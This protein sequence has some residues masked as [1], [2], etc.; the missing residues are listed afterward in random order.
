[1]SAT[2]EDR[3]A[4]VSD[5]KRGLIRD[6]ARS[7]F[8]RS[9]I[10]G[11]SMRAIAAEAGST[12]G[13]IYVHYATKEELYADLLG[14]SLEDLLQTLAA[15][16]MAASDGHG[17]RAVLRA[18][19]GFYRSR[20]QDFDLSFYLHGGA[21]R[22]VGL[23]RELNRRLNAR[24]RE[25]I[26]LVGDALVA[27]GRGEPGDRRHLGTAASASV[28]GIVLMLRTGRLRVLDEDADA[29]LDAVAP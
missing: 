18:L 3:R 25:V 27:D 24:M 19:L 9:G 14:E 6:A 4:R 15:A 29:L 13:A 1:M 17:G 10:D 16:R 28:F 7:V 22:P 12:T 5:F 21:P 26:D 23:S 11:A 20:P 2:A 8:A